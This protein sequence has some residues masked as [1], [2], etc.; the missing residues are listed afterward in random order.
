MTV[1]CTAHLYLEMLRT[2]LRFPDTYH[3]KL[4]Q[5]SLMFITGIPSYHFMCVFSSGNPYHEPLLLQLRTIP[6]SLGN[7][8]YETLQTHTPPGGKLTPICIISYEEGVNDYNDYKEYCRYSNEPHY[9][10]RGMFV[11]ISK[12]FI[13]IILSFRTHSLLQVSPQ[14]SPVSLHQQSPW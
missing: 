4:L 12:E 1:A 11:R 10:G 13:H 14:Q 2:T 3:Y 7:G 8:A 6:L 5:L 9:K